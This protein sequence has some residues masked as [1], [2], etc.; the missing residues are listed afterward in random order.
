MSAEET[1]HDG[2]I[3][4]RGGGDDRPARGRGRGAGLL[5]DRVVNGS[6]QGRRQNDTVL[7][8]EETDNY[9]QYAL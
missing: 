1:P 8:A 9:A 5:L 2:G 6:S 7:T 4:G 3:Q